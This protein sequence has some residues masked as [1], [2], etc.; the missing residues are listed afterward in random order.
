MGTAGEAMGHAAEETFPG[1]GCGQAGTPGPQAQVARQGGSTYK[2]RYHLQDRI[3]GLRI[4]LQISKGN[5][6]GL[7]F[8]LREMY[9]VK[10]MV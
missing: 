1:A 2:C 7:A 10:I 9:C 8:I 5:V 4:V 3:V 6:E